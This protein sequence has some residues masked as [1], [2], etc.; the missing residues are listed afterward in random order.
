MEE[1]PSQGL[2]SWWPGQDQFITGPAEGDKGCKRA[3]DNNLIPT[4][5]LGTSSS[6]HFQPLRFCWILQG[7]GGGWLGW[8]VV[9]GKAS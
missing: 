5:S 8:E 1:F 9:T 7:W 6:L 4:M 3:S 2:V